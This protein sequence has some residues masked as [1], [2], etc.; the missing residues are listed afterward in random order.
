MAW[1]TEG[2]PG[3][4]KARVSG[5][6]QRGQSISLKSVWVGPGMLQGGRGWS[7]H[8]EALFRASLAFLVKVKLLSPV[9][10]FATPWT[11][12]H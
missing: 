7:G 11:V 5:P 9:R 1:P 4:K 3:D 6:W 12:A 8:E 10:L 2:L